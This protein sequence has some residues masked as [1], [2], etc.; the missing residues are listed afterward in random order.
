MK[1]QSEVKRACNSEVIACYHSPLPL[2]PHISKSQML[3]IGPSLRSAFDVLSLK[4]P[5]PLNNVGSIGTEDQIRDAANFLDVRNHTPPPPV[6]DSAINRRVVNFAVNRRNSLIRIYSRFLPA[7]LLL[8]LC[9]AM[10]GVVGCLFG[11]SYSVGFAVACVAWLAAMCRV[12]QLVLGDISSF[13][14]INSLYI[15]YA[16]PFACYASLISIFLVARW[17]YYFRWD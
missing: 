14:V 17:I 3:R 9:A 1:V 7:L 11:R 10:I 15:G 2:I 8:G 5:P 6:P 13:A 4:N 16:Y 12:L